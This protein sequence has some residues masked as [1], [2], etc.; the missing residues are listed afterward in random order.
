MDYLEQ[1]VRET[2]LKLGWEIEVNQEQN[3]IRLIRKN[4][5]VLLVKTDDTHRWLLKERGE[6]EKNIAGAERKPRYTIFQNMIRYII[7]KYNK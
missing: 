1:K 5:E 4:A 2:L 3:I 7:P 6:E